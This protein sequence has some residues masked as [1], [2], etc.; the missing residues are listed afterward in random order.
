MVEGVAV[1]ARGKVAA[2]FKELGGNIVW[3]AIALLLVLVS[4]SFFEEDFQVTPYDVFLL[5]TLAVVPFGI[6]WFVKG[7]AMEDIK[8]M[9][10]KDTSKA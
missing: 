9:F 2:V 8:R 6:S 1:F 10:R 7:E 5:E 4:I 3:I